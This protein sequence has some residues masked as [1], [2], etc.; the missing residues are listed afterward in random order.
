MLTI[1][2]PAKIN[3]ALD[4]LTER[5]DGYHEVDMVMQSISLADQLTLEVSDEIEL[6]CSH[7]QLPCD[8]RNIAWRAANLLKGLTGSP[9]GVKIH[10]TKN[11]PVAAGLAGGSTDAAA[12]L[13]ALNTLWRLELTQ[14]QLMEIGVKLGADVPFCIM[15]GTARAED[16]GE[17]LTSI[18][19]GFHSNLLLIT[20][21]VEVST[22]LIYK[23]LRI[24]RIQH[25]P[26]VSR[27]IQ[28]LVSGDI[29]RLHSV[30]GNVFEEIVLSQF[31]VVAQVKDYFGRFGLVHNLM[32]GSGPSVF[33]LNPPPEV[34][35]PFLAGVPREW[36][37]CLAHF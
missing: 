6:S 12:V 29:Q 26:Q 33:A 34:I 14:T 20:P 3:I 35:E 16:I 17:R 36:F 23:L 21:N 10:I 37:C 1:F 27:V 11:I 30:W 25:R 8:H 18:K 2:A 13:I 24:D 28:A 15:Q 22:A 5:L 31:P 9:G 4:V 19:S 32:S 7:P